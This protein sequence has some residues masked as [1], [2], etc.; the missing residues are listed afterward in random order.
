MFDCLIFLYMK[1]IVKVQGF[2]V[3]TSAIKAAILDTIV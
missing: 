1:L 2:D 3:L